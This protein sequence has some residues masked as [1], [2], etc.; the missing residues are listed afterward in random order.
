MANATQVLSSS[1]LLSIE[2]NTIFFSLQQK[3][4][5]QRT[6]DQSLLCTLDN[7]L[8]LDT[9]FVRIGSWDESIIS[10]TRF[11]CAKPTA[12]TT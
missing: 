8:Q 5:T 2:W 10:R 7:K 6:T 11:R 9:G 3:P 4:C 12:G 1:N